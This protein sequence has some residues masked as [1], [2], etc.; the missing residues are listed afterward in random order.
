MLQRNPVQKFHSN[1]CLP[2]LLADVMNRADIGVVQSGS[3]TRLTA[4][5]F[6]C[7]RV[8]G[9]FF[10]QKLQSHKAAEPSVFGLI[11]DPHSATTEFLDDAVVRNGLA[12]E[13]GRSGHRG[14][15]RLDSLARSTP[16]FS[17]GITVAAP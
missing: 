8:T 3:G 13:L 7:L 4:K 17:A 14:N 6:Q 9:E 2:V 11:H 16:P 15:V 5:A 1:E 12:D 10:R